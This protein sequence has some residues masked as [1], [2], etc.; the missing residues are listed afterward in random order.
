MKLSYKSTSTRSRG[1]LIRW[2]PNQTNLFALFRLLSLAF[3]GYNIQTLFTTN[4]W[5]NT[6]TVKAWNLLLVTERL[7][8]IP[9]I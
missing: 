4:T 5:F 7:D 3:R 1:E 2:K 9:Y 6:V 8:S